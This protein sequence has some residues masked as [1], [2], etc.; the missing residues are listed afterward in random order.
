MPT[1]R[2]AR[3]RSL[4]RGCG[5]SDLARGPG[6]RINCESQ[7]YRT[8]HAIRV[9]FRLVRTLFFRV[10]NHQNQFSCCPSTLSPPFVGTI[11][12][13]IVAVATNADYNFI[14]ALRL[15]LCYVESRERK[16]ILYYYFEWSFDLLP[17]GYAWDPYYRCY[18]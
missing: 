4:H 5:V 6:D 15:Y 10:L 13:V 18:R 1:M 2:K 9:R 11:V 16:A 7:L 17:C 8:V 3:L 14:Q 12:V